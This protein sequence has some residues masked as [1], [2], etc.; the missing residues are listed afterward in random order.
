LT[1]WEVRWFWCMEISHSSLF[2][3]TT[4]IYFPCEFL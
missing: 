1:G 3:M 2:S 4:F